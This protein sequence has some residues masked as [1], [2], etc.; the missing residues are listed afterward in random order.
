MNLC[1]FYDKCCQFLGASPLN[2]TEGL[3][4]PP[5]PQL[6]AM[7]LTILPGYAHASDALL[8]TLVSLALDPL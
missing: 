7:S 3:T 8:L 5:D 2:S 6:V 1:K 4:A